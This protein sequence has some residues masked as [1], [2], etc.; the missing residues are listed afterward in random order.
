MALSCGHV[1][2]S[3]QVSERD[4]EMVGETPLGA[5]ALQLRRG[6]MEVLQT[7]SSGD[8]APTPGAGLSVVSPGG[9]CPAPGPRPPCEQV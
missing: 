8:I 6:A 9:P 7:V 3:V 1:D 5:A 4:R 2:L